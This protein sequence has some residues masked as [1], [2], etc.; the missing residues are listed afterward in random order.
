MIS[1]HLKHSLNEI[2]ADIWDA[3]TGG[4]L[5]ISYGWLKTIE[6]TAIDKVTPYYYLLED[7]EVPVALAVCYESHK[8]NPF[9]LLNG[10]MLG[11]LERI[12]GA[13]GISFKPA[14]LCGPVRGNGDHVIVKQ[15]LSQQQRIAYMRFLIEEIEREAEKRRLS[16]FFTN[17]SE[18]E[19]EL[20][21]ELQARKYNSTVVHPKNRLQIKWSSFADYLSDRETISRKDKETFKYQINKNRK[22]GVRVRLLDEL[23]NEERLYQLLSEHHYRLNKQPFPYTENFIRSLRKNLG[24]DAML[25]V[26]ERAG[27]I[28]GVMILFQRGSEGWATF[29]G[30]DHNLSRNDFTYFNLAYYRVI[31]H[32][33]QAGIK[34]LNYGGMLYR[35][36]K[37][38]GCTLEENYIFHRAST[39]FLHNLLR[40]W[41][42]MHMIW[43]KKRKIPRMISRL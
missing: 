30:M 29:I 22:A 23:E 7:D 9:D 4:R 19:A 15:G 21:K 2:E 11:K 10:F 36:K 42:L 25:L 31:D 35:V 6:E 34:S 5:Y 41:F 12:A 26:A 43:Y 1:V 40:P 37:R 38:R 24:S 14:F 32:A 16:L 33:I 17:V 28:I 18:K 3:L 13:F 20:C 8:D 27:E 39:R